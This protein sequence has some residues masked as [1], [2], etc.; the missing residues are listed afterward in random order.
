MGYLEGTYLLTEMY[1][2][3]YFFSLVRN[4]CMSIE[5]VCFPE[6]IGR[7]KREEGKAS[8]LLELLIDWGK[9]GRKKKK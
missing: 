5:P 4:R 6:K 9:M 7:L 1:I 8:P 3:I 2:D